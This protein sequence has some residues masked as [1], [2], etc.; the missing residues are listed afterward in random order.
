MSVLEHMKSKVKEFTEPDGPGAD[1]LNSAKSALSHGIDG[2]SKFIDEKT[3][4]KYSDHINT[5]VGKAKEFLADKKPEDGSPEGSAGSG[6][7]SDSSSSS[8]QPPQS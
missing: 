2:A 6:P 4:G 3:N 1:M 8:G 7:G 5:G